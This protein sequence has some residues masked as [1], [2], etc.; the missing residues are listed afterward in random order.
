M[1]KSGEDAKENLSKLPDE[2]LLRWSKEELVRRLRKSE[3]DKMSLMMDHGNLM[4]EV[5]RRLQTHLHEIRGLKDV[6]Q[7]L[8]D[9]AQELR[10][11]CCFLD[12][13]RQKAKKLAWE[14]QRFGRYTAAVLRKEVAAQQRR[15][16][17]LEVRQ[18]ALVR[19]NSDLKELCLMLDEERNGGAAGSRGSVG[20]QTSLTGA[21]GAVAPTGG[22]GAPAGVVV[23]A[24]AAVAAPS[25]G[26]G[27]PAGGAIVR[28]GGDGSSSSSSSSGSTS[29][30]DHQHKA[31]AAAAAVAAQGG[32][33]AVAREAQL[34]ASAEDLVDAQ[35]QQ[36]QQQ[37]RGLGYPN[38]V[39]DDPAMYI[40]HLEARVR[41]LEDET[42]NLLQRPSALEAARLDKKG[43]GGPRPLDSPR[44]S[45]P[46]QHRELGQPSGVWA[47]CGG[48][49]GEGSVTARQPSPPSYPGQK[50]EAVVHAMKVLEVHEKLERRAQAR[51]RDMSEKEKAIVREMCNVVWRK[52]G[53]TSGPPPP[54]RPPPPHYPGPV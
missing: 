14:W 3:A 26:A 33:N 29:S 45:P 2:E 42:H 37:I 31:A 19:E 47:L 53:D 13:D 7:R 51:E 12:D 28:D 20:S 21:T 1:A 5:N 9:D 38:G 10:D 44:P 16:R 39:S 34:R 23:A 24:A 6:N 41:Q 52:L 54:A 50:P 36:H 15:L 30:P 8:Q 35:Q 4:K 49:G 40:Q 27:T 25:P 22:V 17:E 18:D 32:A 11:L 48:G 43:P 46:T